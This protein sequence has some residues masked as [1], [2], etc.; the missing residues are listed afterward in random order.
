[1]GQDFSPVV[2]ESTI[3]LVRNLDG[4]VFPRLLDESKGE[5][6]TKKIVDVAS[7]T[8]SYK[9]YQMNMLPRVDA[10]LMAE[11]GV[12]TP[13][14]A[15]SNFGAVLLSNDG[16]LSVLVND[17]DHIVI[18]SKLSGLALE[19]AYKLASDVDD[20]IIPKLPVAFDEDRNSLAVSG[21]CRD[22]QIRASDHEIDMDHRLID[23]ELEA[24]LQC[25]VLKALH[26]VRKALSH[27]KMASGVLIEQCAVKQQAAVGDG[28][29]C[30]NQG[31]LA[32]VLGTFVHL[33]HL[34]QHIVVLLGIPLYSLSVLE[35]DP[36]ILDQLALIA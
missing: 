18:K 20:L 31:T 29:V 32:E 10:L 25:H 30:G 2:V 35:P 5:M 11:K 7:K 13:K 17:T 26:A 12:V 21:L 23:S 1:M 19:K 14:L 34:S 6:V 27:G 9:I 24:L 15:S 28:G 16:N 4:V 8:G 33:K 3:S 22:V 36:E